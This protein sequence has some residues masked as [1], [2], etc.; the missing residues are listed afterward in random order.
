[1]KNTQIIDDWYNINNLS[2]IKGTLDLTNDVLNQ[3]LKLVINLES[4]VEKNNSLVNELSNKMDEISNRLNI[5]LVN[6]DKNIKEIDDDLENE[7]SRVHN[8]METIR[9]E[10]QDTRKTLM[11]NREIFTKVMDK[12]ITLE[13]EEI[14]PILNQIT[15]NQEKITTGSIFLPSFEKTIEQ[16]RLWRLYSNNYRQNVAKNNQNILTQLSLSSE[17][18]I[19]N[20]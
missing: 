16:N 19:Q 3:V 14:K 7:I 8:D 5:N 17:E 20:L 4:K 10:S 1:M 9:Q 11:E 12:F 18:N 6:I 13:K 2:T 15:S